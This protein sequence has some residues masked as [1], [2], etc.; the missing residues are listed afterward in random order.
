MKTK[1]QAADPKAAQQ[2]FVIG[3]HPAVS[4]LQ[5][6]QQSINKVFLQS[7]IDKHNGTVQDI[8][9]LAHE[10][11]LVISEVPRQKLDFMSNHQNH[12]GVVLAIAAYKYVSLQQ[13]FDR[14]NKL[15]Q[16]PFFVI[17]D[18]IEDPHN[19]GS[20]LRTADATGVQGVIIPKRRAVGLTSTVAKASAGA[21]ERVP[22]CRVTN[23][24]QT[25]KTL[26]K[27]DVWVFGTDINGTDYRRW[28]AKGA[29]ALVI[30]NEGK[31]ISRLLKKQVD[32]MLTI[33]MIGK[34]QSLN[35]SVAAGL[36]MYQGY[37]SRHALSKK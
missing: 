25:V 19:L 35:A 26:K 16:Q 23:L 1:E 12:Q 4:A 2:D 3:R 32:E 21:I 29:S 34:I 28:D 36:V 13:L 33:P 6:H 22:V 7:G 15:H 27:K 11:R 37:N 5:S 8:I 10:R 24:V 17:L 20:I 18:R 31:G 14:A 9:R 30:G